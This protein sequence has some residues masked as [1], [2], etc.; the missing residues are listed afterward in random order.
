MTR[1]A[2]DT[3]SAPGGRP[4][5][6]RRRLRATQARPSRRRRGASRPAPRRRRRPEPPSS[7]SRRGCGWRGR[8][9][10]RRRRR[11]GRSGGGTRP[12]S[13]AAASGWR[14][15]QSSYCAPRLPSQRPTPERNQCSSPP[16]AHRPRRGTGRRDRQ[17]KHEENRTAPRLIL[18]TPL[19][20]CRMPVSLSRAADV[21]GQSLYGSYT[22][23]PAI[24]TP[25]GRGRCLRAPSPRAPRAPRAGA[26]RPRA[27]RPRRRRRGRSLS[28][29]RAC[30]AGQSASPRF[31]CSCTQTFDARF[32]DGRGTAPSGAEVR[33]ADAKTRQS[34]CWQA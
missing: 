23:A 7:A 13:P 2:P 19:T 26:C 1:P 8:L 28:L 18:T 32:R 5:G 10:H 15:A 29:S 3:V 20:V 12:S 34:R 33:A 25:S 16:R 14:L 24:A 27:P 6:R 4:G 31:T 22:S 17:R 9:P 21:R 30:T 11:G